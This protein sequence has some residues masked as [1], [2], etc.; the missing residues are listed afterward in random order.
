[1]RRGVGTGKRAVRGFGDDDVMGIGREFGDD[2]TGLLILRKQKVAKT[3]LFLAER[4]IA[5]IRFVTG[6]ACE[7]DLD[8]LS[9]AHVDQSPCVSDDHIAHAIEER[10]PARGFLRRFPVLEIGVLNVDHQERRGRRIK[11]DVVG[12]I[13]IGVVDRSIGGLSAHGFTPS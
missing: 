7:Q 8:A 9:P 13:R 12:L 11:R 4:T 6:D 3:R 1:M 10:L 5:P 2:L